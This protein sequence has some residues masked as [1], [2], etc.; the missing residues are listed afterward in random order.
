MLEIT[1][2]T[3]KYKNASQA[4]SNVLMVISNFRTLYLKLNESFDDYYERMRLY[5]ER[6]FMEQRGVVVSNELT[7]P[8]FR[9]GKIFKEMN[10]VRVCYESA[11]RSFHNLISKEGEVKL[12]KLAEMLDFTEYYS[13]KLDQ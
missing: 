7:V 9:S 11:F 4:L 2:C 1:L 8:E 6:M 12:K 5:E 3:P 13:S 10:E